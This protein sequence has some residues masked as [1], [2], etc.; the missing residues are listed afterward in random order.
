MNKIAS[1]AIVLTISVAILVLGKT[2]LIP[3][4]FAFL[5]WLLLRKFRSTLDLIPLFNKHIPRWIKTILGALFF[6]SIVVFIGKLIQAN[7]ET[8]V[9]SFEHD[10]YQLNRLFQELEKLIPISLNDLEQTIMQSMGKI[11]SFVIQ[12]LSS[13]VQNA[14]II[15]LYVIFIFLEESSF[16]LKLKALFPSEQGYEKTASLFQAIEKSVTNYIGLKTLIAFI[17]SGLALI[18]LFFSKIDAP[19]FWA[20][21]IFI[22]NFVPTIG[23][24]IGTIFPVLFAFMQFN[25]FTP[26]LMILF[27]VGGI[28]LI[29]GNFLEPRLMGNSL[30]ISPLAAIFSLAFWGTIWGVPGMFLSVP[31]TVILVIICAQFTQT[32][33]IAILLSEKGTLHSE[34]V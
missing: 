3:F 14:M 27:L 13:I 11:V 32:R 33:A 29:V 8:L 21:I 9:R 18:I 31:I 34:N 6:I 25:S 24:L 12:S 5:I 2:L 4:V 26:G 1:I 23:A 20:L 10:R 15:L 22:M 7:S 28:Q 16:H 17:A 30:N 19:F